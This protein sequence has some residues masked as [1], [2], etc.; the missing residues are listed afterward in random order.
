[1]LTRTLSEINKAHE[2]GEQRDIEDASRYLARLIH[3]LSGFDILP[4]TNAA[5]ELYYSYPASVKRI[6]K[7]DC[8]LAAHAAVSGLIAVT[9][10]T[11][12]FERIPGVTIEDC[13]SG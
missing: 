7:M 9:C 6:G 4:C 5:E 12:D 3:R 1:M 2:P 10:N 11:A 8:R 13:S